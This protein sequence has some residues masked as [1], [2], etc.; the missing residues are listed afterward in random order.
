MSNTKIEYLYRDASNYKK[1][2]TAIVKGHITQSQIKNIID[3]LDGYSKSEG[4]G[5][6]IPEQVCL[7]AE[8]FDDGPTEDDHCWFE[9]DEEGFASTTQP[10]TVDISVKD[11]VSL[12]IKA[13]NDGWD[14]IKYAYVG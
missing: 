10:P 5:Y 1:T 9:L 4:Y 11:L 2:N 13:K 14:D 12:F 6:F 7:P 8:R 3:S